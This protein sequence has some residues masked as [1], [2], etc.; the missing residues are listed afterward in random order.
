MTSTTERYRAAASQSA[1]TVEKVADFWTQGSKKLT[2]YMAAGLPQVDRDQIDLR[3]ARS[4][5]VSQL[6]RALRPEVS[7]LL[8][9]AGR[10]ARRGAVALGGASHMY[11]LVRS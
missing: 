3:Q 7:D 9:R 2:D 8:D 4:H 5:V 11:S 1:S 6:F 10:L